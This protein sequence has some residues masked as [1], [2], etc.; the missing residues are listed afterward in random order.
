MDKYLVAIGGENFEVDADD[1]Q[2][3]RYSAAAEFKSAHPEISDSS[4]TSIA[5]YAKARMV[6]QPRE[7]G[8][9]TKELIKLLKAEIKEKERI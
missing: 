3:A 5:N 6:T 4:L 8:I 9:S 7:T 2:G 1:N